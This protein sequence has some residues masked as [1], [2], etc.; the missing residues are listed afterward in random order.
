MHNGFMSLS[1]VFNNDPALARVRNI[2]KESDVTIEFGK[3]FP[4]LEKVAEVV[5]VEKMVLIL[6]VENPAWRNELRFKENIIVEKINKYFNELRIN[7]V[8]F[9][10]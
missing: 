5:K 2:V 8:K 10:S 9:V 6:K 1:E 4:D 3:I 7:R